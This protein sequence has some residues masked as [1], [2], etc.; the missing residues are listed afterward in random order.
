MIKHRIWLG[1]IAALALVLS[2]CAAKSVSK[3]FTFDATKNEGIVVVAVSH[4]LSGG[5]AGRGLF[6]INGG[7]ME[8]NGHMLASLV[9]VVPGIAGGSDFQESYGKLFVLS[10]P[11]GKHAFTSWQF[12]N[13]G[14]VGITPRAG[15]KPLEFQVVAGEIKYLG[16]L[17]LN[18]QMGKVLGMGIVNDGY[19]E[20]RDQRTLD[21]AL[22]DAKYPQFKGKVAM[23]LLKLGPWVA[24][25]GNRSRI[26]LPP[27]VAPPARAIKN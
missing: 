18:L 22:F 10:L 1:V 24:D 2:G 15:L 17:H 20:V 27:P 7:Q 16:N 12:T 25:A 26:D 23:D 6:Y 5:R 11:A 4:E 13:G 3:D 21:L 14:G 19:P 9:E 8:T